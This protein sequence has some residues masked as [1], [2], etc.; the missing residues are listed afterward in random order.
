[1]DQEKI[2]KTILKLRKENNLTQKEFADLFG[3]TYQAVSK[4]ETGKNIPDIAVLKAISEKFHIDLSELIEGKEKVSKRGNNRLFIALIIV[5]VL[6]IIGLFFFRKNDF[7]FKQIGTTCS[8]FKLTGNMAYNKNKTAIHI[9]NINYCGKK[10]DTKYQKIMCNLY[11]DYDGDKHLVEKCLAKK[12]VTIENYLK[13]VNISVDNYK[14]MC[15]K[16][17]SSSLF[18]E[19]IT[20]DDKSDETIYKIPLSIEDNCSK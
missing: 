17:D 18:L 15:K 8:S 1:M 20:F 4:W 10:D 13:D 3:V 16:F 9:S 6:I 2:G 12:D 14:S 11:E 7:E 5:I 19:I